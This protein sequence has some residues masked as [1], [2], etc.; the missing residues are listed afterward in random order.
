MS[1]HVR[2]YKL[3]ESELALHGRMLQLLERERVALV[4]IREDE[5]LS[6]NKEKESLVEELRDAEQ[7]RRALLDSL[8]LELQIEGPPSFSQIVEKC[9]AKDLRANLQ[10]V[11]RKLKTSV[12]KVVQLTEHNAALIRQTLGIV[13]STL[14]ILKGLPSVEELCVYGGS[15]SMKGNATPAPVSAS[16]RLARS[17]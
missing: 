1:D 6:L 4:E 11:G 12:E 9:S 10:A 16:G 14:S 13:A 5:I 3:L 17:A 7:R 2:L 15:G 8:R